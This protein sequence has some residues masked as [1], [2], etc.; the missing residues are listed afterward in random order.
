VSDDVQCSMFNELNKCNVVAE[1]K[2]HARVLDLYVT[3]QSISPIFISSN[4]I[5]LK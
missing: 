4:G 5:I 2:A 3:D 1:Q